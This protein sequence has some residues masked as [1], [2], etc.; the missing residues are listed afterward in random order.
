MLKIYLII[1]K[2]IIEFLFLKVFT[3]NSKAYGFKENCSILVL[4]Q[5][6]LII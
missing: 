1:L 2:T 5:D 3:N 6:V 4:N